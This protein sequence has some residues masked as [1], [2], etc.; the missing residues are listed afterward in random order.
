MIMHNDGCKR[1]SEANPML[2][3]VSKNKC[4]YIEK[5]IDFNL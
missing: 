3:L 4:D 2:L 5:G 1:V